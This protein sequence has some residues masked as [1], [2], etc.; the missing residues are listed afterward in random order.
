M[1]TGSSIA[2]FYADILL[3]TAIAAGDTTF[4]LFYF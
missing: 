4:L 1:K 2:D 3:K